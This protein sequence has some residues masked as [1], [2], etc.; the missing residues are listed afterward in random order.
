VH[1]AG[2]G[3]PGRAIDWGRTSTDYAT[4]RPGPPAS[5]FERLASFG[6]GL[7]GQRILDL[8]TGTGVM[9]R[10]FARRGAS[11]HDAFRR[12]ESKTRAVGIMP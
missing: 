4:H 5:L 12:E 8:G 3:D 10:G 6:V 2:E 9:A 1:R 11:R 7:A